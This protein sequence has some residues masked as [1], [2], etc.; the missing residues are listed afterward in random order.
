MSPQIRSAALSLAAI[1]A[2]AAVS[3]ITAAALWDGSPPAACGAAL[4]LRALPHAML[5][6]EL[7]H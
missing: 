1:A 5:L 2:L 4:S 6:E 3:A 7:W